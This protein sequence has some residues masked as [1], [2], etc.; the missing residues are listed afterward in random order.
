[1]NLCEH[2]HFVQVVFEFLF[3][4]QLVIKH[5]RKLS[6]CEHMYFVQ[7]VF[8]FLFIGQLVRKNKKAEPPP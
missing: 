2:M 3:I 7:V 8:G 1:M 4:G 5:I 6:L